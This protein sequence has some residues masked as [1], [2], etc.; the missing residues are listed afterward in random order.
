MLEHGQPNPYAKDEKGITPL[1]TACAMLDW[2]TFE[3]LI[4]KGGD[5]MLPDKDGN[6]FLH[7]MCQGVVK[8]IEYD[9][10]KLA[11]QSFN[12]KL[13]RNN[14]G[15]TPLDILRGMQGA[16]AGFVRGQP[17]YKRRLQDYLD[18]MTQR[19]PSF[20]DHES[21]SDFH[22]SIIRNQPEVFE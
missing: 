10:A 16:A 8:D 1:H 17:N 22:N 3:E 9:F 2:E 15:K 11:L 7:L 6:T 18:R 4:N 20:V 5:A 21:N 19:D 14:R 12:I 13:T